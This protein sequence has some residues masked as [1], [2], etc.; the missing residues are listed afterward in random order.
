MKVFDLEKTWTQN[1]NPEDRFTCNEA[2]ILA[3]GHGKAVNI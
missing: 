3:A 1:R 2:Q